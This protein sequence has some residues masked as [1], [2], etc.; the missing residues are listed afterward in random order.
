MK[1]KWRL[2][3]EFNAYFKADSLLV[4]SSTGSSYPGVYLSPLDDK[5]SR[6]HVEKICGTKYVAVRE[7]E[8]NLM[9]ATV[10]RKFRIFVKCVEFPKADQWYEC[11]NFSCDLDYLG[12]LI[13]SHEI[14]G[15]VFDNTFEVVFSDNYPGLVSVISDKM[16]KEYEECNDEFVRRLNSELCKKTK[17]YIP[18]HRY[19]TP[20]ETI[21][22]LCPL[23]SRLKNFY[24]SNFLENSEVVDAYLYVNKIRDGYKKVSDVLSNESIISS[25]DEDDVYSIKIGFSIPNRSDS[26]E[27]LE[28]DITGKKSFSEFRESLVTNFIKKNTKVN[29]NGYESLVRDKFYDIFLPYSLITEDEVYSTST[30]PLITDDSRLLLKDM[31]VKYIKESCINVSENYTAKGTADERREKVICMFGDPN[32]ARYDYYTRLFSELGIKDM[33]E[34]KSLV[35]LDIKSIEGDSEEF[36]KYHPIFS[37]RAVKTYYIYQGP[38]FADRCEYKVSDLFSKE[39]ADVIKD[40]VKG[41]SLLKSRYYESSDFK[42]FGTVRKPDIVASLVITYENIYN[43]IIDKM[44]PEAVK[45]LKN[46]L[47]ES[48]FGS[49]AIHVSK[50][51]MEDLD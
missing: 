4:D 29:W 28:D 1:N 15:G 47:R 3:S 10:N 50:S 6:K 41:C 19:D 32:Y 21:Y 49:I 20:K 45:T 27:V 30:I 12:K 2:T 36:F 5:V 46:E 33:I 8:V 38:T 16:G 24:N 34:D 7:N 42:N 17:K 13:S 44:D 48:F 9:L 51:K 22:Y 31:I 26:G 25:L 23:K 40:I 43:Y 39:L 37:F 35:N 14:K 18:G 11:L